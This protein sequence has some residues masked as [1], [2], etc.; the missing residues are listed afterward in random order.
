MALHL[1]RIYDYNAIL[2]D[3][4]LHLLEVQGC[5]GKAVSPF[6]FSLY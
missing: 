3:I 6:S 1:L 2:L 4:L 5:L